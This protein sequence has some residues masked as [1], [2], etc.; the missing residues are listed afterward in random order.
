MSALFDRT[1]LKFLLVGAVNTLVGSALMFGL[2]NIAGWGYWLSS[3]V[4]YALT[5]VL[6]F[7]L[8]KRFTFRAQGWSAFMVTAFILTIAVSYILAYGIAKP[9]IH[10][11]LRNQSPRL[12]DNAALFAGMCLFTGLN[13][14]GQRFVAFRR[15]QAP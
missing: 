6:S 9:A 13:Y 2:Y 8:N 15:R 5:S 3:A 10:F 7:F 1:F 12:R 4:N 14:M 11:L